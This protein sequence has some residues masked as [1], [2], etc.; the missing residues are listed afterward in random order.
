LPP[1]G[2]G[3]KLEKEIKV[4]KCIQAYLRILLGLPP[5]FFA[6]EDVKN[7]CARLALNRDHEQKYHLVV[8]DARQQ[9]EAWIVI[10]IPSRDMTEERIML[11]SYLGV[12]N[13]TTCGGLEGK[14]ASGFLP[15]LEQHSESELINPTI[16]PTSTHMRFSWLSH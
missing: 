13:E 14:A 2:A 7:S 5:L 6:Y 16:N 3:E 11:K 9:D 1:E 15:D 4:C 10:F 12:V 8:E